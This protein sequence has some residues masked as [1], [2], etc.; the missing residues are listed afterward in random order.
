[1]QLQNFYQQNTGIFQISRDQGS[2]FAKQLAGDFN[3]LH[4]TDAKRFVVPGD[5]LFSLVLHS[6]GIFPQMQFAFSGMVTEETRFRIEQQDNE[7]AVKDDAKVYTKVAVQG[8]ATQ[9]ADFIAKLCNEYVEFSG[10]TY[11]HILVPLMRDKGLMIN[12]QRPMVMYQSMNIQFD[13]EIASFVSG[14]PSLENAK[15][16]F[17]ADGKRGDV[18]LHFNILVD[19]KQ[20]GRG[21]KHMLL[22]GLREFDEAAINQLTAE[23]DADKAA[24]LAKATA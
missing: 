8:D 18:H 11:P 5:L 10:K 20:V 6:Q 21:E 7:I 22:S 9:Q 15:N 16:E 2:D 4:D 14:T 17:I 24:Y 19:G 13:A 12:P 3:P 23:Y 1:M